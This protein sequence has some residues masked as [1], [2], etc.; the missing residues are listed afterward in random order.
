MNQM[1]TTD[2]RHK[3][4]LLDSKK[5]HRLDHFRNEDSDQKSHTD[6]NSIVQDEEGVGTGLDNIQS[7]MKKNKLED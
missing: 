6:E 4:M 2:K 7:L 1:Q 5:P 3:S